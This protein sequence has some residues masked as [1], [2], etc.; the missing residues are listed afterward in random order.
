VIPAAVEYVRPASLDDA[1]IELRAHDTSVLAGGHSLLPMMKLRLTQPSRVLDIGGLEL[2]G[3]RF[4]GSALEIGA[5]AT[6]SEIAASPVV[7]ERWSA[8]ADGAAVVGD[9]Q[10]RN[11]GTIGGG[12]AHADPAADMP[13]ALLALGASVRLASSEGTR[14]VPVSEFFVGP[15]TTARH[16][17]E[18]VVAIVV[19]ESPVGQA[20]AYS[21]FKDPASGYPL[22]GAAARIGLEGGRLSFAVAAFTGLTGRAFLDEEVAGRLTGV[23]PADVGAVADEA[24]AAIE[25]PDEP[26]IDGVY[27]RQLGRVALQRALTTAIQRAEEAR[28]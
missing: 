28:E 9:L 12:V 22:A 23:G 14:D 10:V 26:R 4:A 21:A 17:Q 18:L 5:L 16:E 2:G 8:V 11:W 6:W 7:Q 19:P 13:A 20:S 27:R 1:L 24:L 3:I 15:F 25:I